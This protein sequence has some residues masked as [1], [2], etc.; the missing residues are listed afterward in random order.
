MNGPSGLVFDASGNLYVANSGGNT[1][2]RFTPGGAASVF[3]STGLSG[4]SGLAFTND[5]GVPLP[6]IPAVAL[7]PRPAAVPEPSTL[8]LFALGIAVLFGFRRVSYRSA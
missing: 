6:L 3:A 7:M 8:A 2:E 1:V 5:V 4:P